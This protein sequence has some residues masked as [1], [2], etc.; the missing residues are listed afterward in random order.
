MQFAVCH[1]VYQANQQQI[2]RHEKQES[3]PGN[4][5]GIESNTDR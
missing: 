3:S 5:A 1:G 2:H 4:E